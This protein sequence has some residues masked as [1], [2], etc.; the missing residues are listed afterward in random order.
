MRLLVVLTLALISVRA[1]AFQ[2]G[3]ITAVNQGIVTFYRATEPLTTGDY[4]YVVDKFDNFIADLSVSSVEGDYARA[5]VVNNHGGSLSAVA[6]G[7]IVRLSIDPKDARSLSVFF[8]GAR[9]S[10]ENGGGASLGLQLM[11]APHGGWLF[12]ILAAVDDFGS[13]RKSEFMVQTT[14]DAASFFGHAMPGGPQAVIGLGMIEISRAG[15]P[16]DT[17]SDFFGGRYAGQWEFPIVVPGRVK[18]WGFSLVPGIAIS[19]QIGDSDFGAIGTAYLG[20]T[21]KLL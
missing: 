3:E 4:V 20:A 14:W 7:A 19:Q 8:G 5:V 18:R 12:G 9:A 2:V 13:R 10:G 16:A 1:F 21:F 15:D 11:T 6:P 17:H